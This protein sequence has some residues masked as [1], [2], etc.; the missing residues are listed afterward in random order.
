MSTENARSRRGDDS[1]R[2]IVDVAI[3]CFSRDGYQATSIDRIARAAGVT[4]GAIYYHFRDKQELLLGALEDRVDGFERRIVAEVTKLRDPAAVIDRVAEICLDQATRGN[5]RRF[6]LTLMVEALDTHPEISTRFRKTIARFRGF[7][8]QT[9]KIGQSKKVFRAD[10]DPAL[11]AQLFVAG[12]MGNE[13]QYYQDRAAI[14]LGRS[15]RAFAAQFR[16]WLA[17]PA[18]RPRPKAVRSPAKHRKESR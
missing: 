10:V 7:L 13:I 18:G 2:A 5:H 12:V 17:A 4:K 6:L 11:A 1:R 16:D 8:E 15:L 9:V 14:D 3:D